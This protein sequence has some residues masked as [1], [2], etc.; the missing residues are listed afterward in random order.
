VLR[1][2]DGRC[3]VVDVKAPHKRFDVRTSAVEYEAVPHFLL[4]AW[5]APADAEIPADQLWYHLLVLL[6][7]CV[8]AGSAI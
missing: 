3:I 5:E 1:R 8:Y 2:A 6:P 7:S 4:G